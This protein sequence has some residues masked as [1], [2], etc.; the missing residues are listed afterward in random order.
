MPATPPWRSRNERAGR[1]RPARRERLRGAAGAARARPARGVL[2]PHRHHLAASQDPGRL[3]PD[4]RLAHLRAP[5]AIGRRRDDLRRAALRHRHHR[6]ARPRRA[7]RRQR[8]T[9]SRGAGPARAPSRHPPAVPG[10]L[11]PL[12]SDQARPVARRVAPVAQVHAGRAHP[13]LL[14]QRDRDHLHPGRGRLP[15]LA[16]AGAAGR[17]RAGAAGAAGG[18]RAGRRG[19]GPVPAPVRATGR[20]S[21]RASCRRAARGPCP[22]WGRTRATCW[23]SPSW[24]TPRARWRNAVPAASRRGFPLGAEGTTG[25]AAGGGERV[26]RRA[27]ALPRRHRGG[28]RTGRARRRPA[29]RPARRQ[30][31]LLLPRLAARGAAGALPG[32]RAGHAAVRGRHARSCTASTWPR[33]WPCCRRARG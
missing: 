14:R 22:R 18:G 28:A 11:L 3:L 32:Q 15:R 33:N 24:P 1:H 29:S 27:G 12:G 25:V 31:H 13:Q 6:G 21:G 9:R 30:A 20:G 5:D 17:G 10:R 7:G 2:R 8:G 4:R 26:G 23:R 16:G 19:R